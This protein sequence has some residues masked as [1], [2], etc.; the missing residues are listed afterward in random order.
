MTSVTV[1]IDS[2]LR[3]RLNAL[4]THPRESYNEVIVPAFTFF[5]TASAV[6]ICGA[7]PVFA[8]VDPADAIAKIS[9][10]T[11]AVIGVHLYGQPCDAGTIR[12]ICGDKGLVFIEDAA[13][14]HG[15]KYR[16][17]RTGALGRPRLLLVLTPQRTWRPGRRGMVT[18]A[19]DEYD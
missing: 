18:T 14:A 17:I 7:R 3:D 11:K 2:D 4:K 1:R 16:G 13:Q 9:S 15:A 8:D 10:K 5:A 19:S 6:S 12:G